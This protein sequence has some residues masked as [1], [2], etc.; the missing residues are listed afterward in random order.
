MKPE[1]S[2]GV[3]GFFP[4]AIAHRADQSCTVRA[5]NL[6]DAARAGVLELKKR[7]GN[8]KHFKTVKLTI[9]CMGSAPDKRGQY[10][11]AD[12]SE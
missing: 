4:E 7:A 6:A 12:G 5:S 11:L 1:F 8:G 2:Y 10:S 9:T 3:A